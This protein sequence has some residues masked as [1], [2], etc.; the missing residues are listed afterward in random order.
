MIKLFTFCLPHYS[1]TA[2][3][4]VD[5]VIVPSIRLPV[6]TPNIFRHIGYTRLI[7]TPLSIHSVQNVCLQFKVFW[8]VIGH[9]H[10]QRSSSLS[11][12]FVS[13][14]ISEG[15]SRLGLLFSLNEVVVNFLFLLLHFC[16][17]DTRMTCLG[18]LPYILPLVSFDRGLL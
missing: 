2:Y 12:Y 10:K 18:R 5:T 9:I 13:I 16:R 3:I 1:Q 15:K 4:I 8:F 6:K 14:T 11:S 17:V 7:F